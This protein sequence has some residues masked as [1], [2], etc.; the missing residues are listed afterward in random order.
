MICYYE[1]D[2]DDIDGNRGLQTVSME[3]TEDD[4]EDIV[5]FVREFTPDIFEEGVP[6][7]ICADLYCPLTEQEEFVCI[8]VDTV[9]GLS[10]ALEELRA[11]L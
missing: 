1:F 7:I 5:E 6:E 11:S 10:E 8:Q 9:K 2:Y 4:I 3:V